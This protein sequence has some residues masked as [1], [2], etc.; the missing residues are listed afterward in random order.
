MK[1]SGALTYANSG[2]GTGDLKVTRDGLGITRVKGSL[3][4]PGTTG[5][6]AKVTVDVQ[7]AWILPFWTGS[8]AVSDPGAGVKVT[9]P[10]IGGLSAGTTADSATTTS[11]WFVLGNFPNLIRPY[12]LTWSV[13]DAGDAPA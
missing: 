13:I 12:T 6:T 2:T 3:N 5:G 11:S 7:R 9:T 1:F 10:V 8:V 4:V